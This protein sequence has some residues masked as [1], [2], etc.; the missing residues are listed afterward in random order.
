MVKLVGGG[1]VI[2]GAYPFCFLFVHHFRRFQN[3]HDIYMEGVLLQSGYKTCHYLGSS[4]NASN[5]ADDCNK[6]EK[7]DFAKDCE[8]KGGLFKCCI[9][10]DAIFDEDNR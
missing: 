9:R 3:D 7:E 8:L 10:R 4:L 1:S 2:N 6:L 5:C